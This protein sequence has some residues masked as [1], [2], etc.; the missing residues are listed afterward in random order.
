MN[1]ANNKRKKETINK[2]EAS[3]LNLLKEKEISEITVTDICTKTKI[4]RSTFYSNFIDISELANALS[5]KIEE[6]I[7]ATYKKNYKTL[8][9]LTNLFNH[10]YLNKDPYQTFYKLN[11]NKR[12]N[13]KKWNINLSSKYYDD[14]FTDYHLEFFESGINGLIQKWLNSDLSLTPNEMSEIIK[15]EY[16]QKEL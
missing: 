14:F 1:K 5:L 4:N 2:I 13:F 16:K 11:K 8:D 15:N 12:L 9:H 7:I 6:E 10:I 3:L